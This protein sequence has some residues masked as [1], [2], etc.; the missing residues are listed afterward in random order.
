MNSDPAAV[1]LEL[2]RAVR[3]FATEVVK[4]LASR[5]D[6]EHRF[7]GEILS[8]AAELDLM[9]ILIPAEYGGAGLDHLAFAIC[10]EEIATACA[11]TAGVGAVHTGVGREPIVV[12]GDEDQK[13]S[14]LPRLAR[15]EVLGAFA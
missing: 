6:Q 8:A 13:R 14:W 9:G 7:P 15:G 4:P 5:T 12:F 11:S 2:R 1:H 3:D 10:I